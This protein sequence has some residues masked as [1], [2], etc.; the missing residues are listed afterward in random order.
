MQLHILQ[1]KLSGFLILV[2][3]PPRRFS[4]TGSCWPALASL[5]ASVQVSTASLTSSTGSNWNQ[6]CK[7]CY[8]SGSVPLVTFA[9]IWM[10]QCSL[11][12]FQ[13][14]IEFSIWIWK[15]NKLPSRSLFS[16]SAG[17]NV[18][19]ARDVGL[20]CCEWRAPCRIS[21]ARGVID[22][23]VS[24]SVDSEAPQRLSP[25]QSPALKMSGRVRERSVLQLCLLK[26]CLEKI[27]E[28]KESL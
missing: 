27:S 14:L 12:Y 16:V 4:C 20:L 21:P 5:L 19:G 11:L 2:F 15:G 24:A 28:V 22:V 1:V 23:K 6:W 9:P 25:Q 3:F 10:P 18:R 26:T 17:L 13:N 8:H 7:V